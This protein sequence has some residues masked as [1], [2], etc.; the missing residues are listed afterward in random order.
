MPLQ[1]TGVAMITGADEALGAHQRVA[2][3]LWR[4]ALRGTA[5]AAAVR[6]MIAKE[7]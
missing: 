1:Q 7:G 4:D 6:A 3:A 5:A 2:E